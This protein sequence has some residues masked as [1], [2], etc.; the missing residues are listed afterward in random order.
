M[1]LIIPDCISIVG[2]VQKGVNHLKTHAV[3]PVNRILKSSKLKKINKDAPQIPAKFSYVY[4]GTD[5]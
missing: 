4:M 3:L 1:F 2:Q 5:R